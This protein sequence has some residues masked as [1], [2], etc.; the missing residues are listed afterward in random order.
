MS[1]TIVM[2]RRAYTSAE[3]A[4]GFVWKARTLARARVKPRLVEARRVSRRGA[5][6]G[7]RRE[8]AS[9][10]RGQREAAADGDAQ[11]ISLGRYETNAGRPQT[12]PQ[13]LGAGER[14]A[15]QR[16]RAVAHVHANSVRPQQFELA[17]LRFRS[18]AM[19][20]APGRCLGGVGLQF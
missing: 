17:A 11:R 13:R 16:S 19:M 15:A 1:G 12:L 10:G 8:G 14:S 3:R 18:R 6:V 5:R 4:S 20:Q 2:A 9:A 7:L